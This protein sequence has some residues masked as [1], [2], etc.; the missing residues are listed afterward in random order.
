MLRPEKQK[1][2][3]AS[4]QAKRQKNEIY[5]SNQK[6]ES[7]D[8]KRGGS[9]RD[10]AGKTKKAGASFQAN[11]KKRRVITKTKVITKKVG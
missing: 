2:A 11:S 7:V 3:G 10:A 6:D 5:R 9:T 4:F 1:K 8:I